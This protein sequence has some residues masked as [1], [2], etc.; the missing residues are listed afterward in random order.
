MELYDVWGHKLL[1]GK[2]FLGVNRTTFV[3]DETGN[4]EAILEKVK[5]T[6]HVEKLL[7]ALG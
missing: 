7:E 2:T 5:P 3:I 6:T 4:I 1:Y